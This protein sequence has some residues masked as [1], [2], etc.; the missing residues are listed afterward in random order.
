MSK[1]INSS[2]IA[3]SVLKEFFNYTPKEDHDDLALCLV[4]LSYS[5]GSV[6]TLIKYFITDEFANNNSGQVMRENCIATKLIK[7]YLKK[8]GG[9]YLEETLSK[10]VTA[11]VVNEKKNNYEINPG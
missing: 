2:L 10:F 1:I 7:A 8:F 5:T 3:C 11:I 9:K 6:F 4:S